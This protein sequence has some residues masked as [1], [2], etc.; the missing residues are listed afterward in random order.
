MSAADGTNIVKVFQQAVQEAKR[1]KASG[2]DMLSDMLD[3]LSDPKPSK[4]D[5]NDKKDAE[6]DRKS[7]DKK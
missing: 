2:G 4:L 3:L 7:D 6:S 5:P 1:F